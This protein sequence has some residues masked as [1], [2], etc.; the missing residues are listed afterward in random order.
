MDLSNTYIILIGIESYEDDEL[1]DL[2][3]AFDN[4]AALSKIFTKQLGIP[5][6]QIKRLID[7]ED[8]DDLLQKLKE[9][10]KKNKIKNLI[11][12]YA[13][14]GVMDDDMVNYY[15]TMMN[16]EVDDLEFTGLTI[17]KLSDRLGRNNW[18]ITLILDSCFS[19]KAFEDFGQRNFYV[20]ASSARNKTSKYPLNEDHSAFTGKL[21]EVMQNGIT[22]GKE[23]LSFEDIFA[24]MKV[25]L[26]AEG[27][28][29][30][31]KASRNDAG[32]LEFFP[33]AYKGENVEVGQT[34]QECLDALYDAL[35][36]Y[37]PSFVDKRNNIMSLPTFQQELKK[38]I[39]EEYPYPI[40][41][42][43]K[44]M[45]PYADG[46][47]VPYMSHF[48]EQIIKFMGLLVIADL[49]AMPTENLSEDIHDTLEMLDRPRLKFYIRII[50]QALAEHADELFM[51]EF[52]DNQKAFWEAVNALEKCR[53]S[54]EEDREVWEKHLVE[55][56]ASIAFIGMYQMVSV[57]F[58][59]VMTSYKLN[60]TEY[61]HQMSSLHGENLKPYQASLVL[62]NKHLHSSSILLFRAPSY[63]ELSLDSEYV[64]LWPMIIDV[65]SFEA[66]NSIPQLHLYEGKEDDEYIYK[67]VSNGEVETKAYREYQRS[68]SKDALQ[69]L[70]EE[71]ESHVF[72]Q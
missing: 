68:L 32:S 18:N 26:T 25:K 27:F 17:K 63:S 59:D 11:L 69:A 31:K 29:A 24:E 54:D 22:N 34:D 36:K 14:H 62:S 41:Y 7:V 1:H 51:K 70:F 40:A 16:T 15:L 66:K 45:F 60:R 49:A 2:P 28:P 23:L 56:L 19:E 61:R 58:I 21:I 10:K 42:Y 35:V 52:K 67:L 71:F 5:R 8:P 43:L 12:Y 50:K 38:M 33:N 3:S 48:Y 46:I 4:V 37:H 57:R 6:K 55:L 13:G 72:T 53:K 64:N 44:N 39:L 20:M 9:I 65:N 47:D 30:P